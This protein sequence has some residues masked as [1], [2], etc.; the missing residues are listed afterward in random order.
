[1]AVRLLG[2]DPDA[3]PGPELYAER[4]EQALALRQ[5]Y[6]RTDIEAYRVINAEGDLLPGLT[7]D[8]YGEYLVAQVFTEAA[9]PLAEVVY[10]L[11]TDRLGARGLFEQMRLRP[12]AGEKRA[13]AKLILG[14]APPVDYAVQEYGCRFLVDVSAP[15]GV[16]L[17]PDLREARLWVGEQTEGKKVLNTFSYT[18]AFTVHALRGGA[19]EVVAVDLSAKLHA[20]ARKNIRL[21]GLDPELRSRHLS[22]DVTAAIT[23]LETDGE[24]FDLAI[25]DPPSFS[26]GPSGTFSTARDYGDLIT[27]T[28]RLVRPGG[29]ILAVANTAK[30]TDD[31]LSRSVGRGGLRAGR[32]LRLLRRFSQPPDF[33]APPA[34]AEGLYLKAFLLQA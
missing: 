18:G 7:V 24:Q 20:W 13:P 9:R 27:A 32:E 2:R 11:L 31:E 34:F 21:N 14:K 15:L 1:M 12:T 19:A 16:G 33:P 5:P 25:L 6:L 17:F 26:R 4:A 28:L 29:Q 3:I 22:A 10:P 23:R 8:R 30:L